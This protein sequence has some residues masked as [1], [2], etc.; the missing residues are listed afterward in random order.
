VDTTISKIEVAAFSE[1]DAVIVN[2]QT[3]YPNGRIRHKNCPL[4]QGHYELQST[5]LV[6]LD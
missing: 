3:V 1:F 4:S 6:Q 2:L 5:S